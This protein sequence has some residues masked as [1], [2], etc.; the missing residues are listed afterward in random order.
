MSD[1]LCSEK[2]SIGVIV[3]ATR[4]GGSRFVETPKPYIMVA[5]VQRMLPRAFMSKCAARIS[6]ILGN[7]MADWVLSGTSWQSASTS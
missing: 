7:T 6:S 1:F 5:G 3:F 2:T 4:G